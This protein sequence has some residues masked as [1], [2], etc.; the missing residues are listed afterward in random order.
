MSIS[1]LTVVVTVDEKAP[2]PTSCMRLALAL[3]RE[4]VTDFDF[5]LVANA[6]DL[7]TSLALKDF[8]VRVPDSTVVFLNSH[9]P[10]DVARLIGI[11]HA[12]GDYILFCD[13]TEE[14]LAALSALL[15]PLRDGF[16]L[17]IADPQCG[18]ML[19]Q[20]PWL[21]WLLL[22][23]YTRIY[24]L[25]TDVTLESRPTGF[26]VVSRA[27]ALFIARHPA[28]EFMLRIRNIGPG[29][30]AKVLPLLANVAPHNPGS[31]RDNWAAGVKSLIGT[32]TMPLR[33]AAYL[34]L[35]GGVLS[36][37]WGIYAL[38]S[39]ILRSNVAAGWTTISLQIA[40]MMFIFSLLFMLLSEYVL[41]IHASNLPRRLSHLVLRELRS[42][43]SRR[44]MRLNV[45]DAQGRFHIGA[46]PMAGGTMS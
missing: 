41:Q 38:A 29:F 36:L 21:T 14:E 33:A 24:R 32:T 19:I 17:V 23:A 18:T 9:Q 26:R 5:V 42:P 28:A 3:E 30:P 27:A 8:V 12:V 4:D 6:V 34:G 1:S 43:L 11:D 16:D 7:A 40:A 20:R 2:S 13:L 22:R 25:L 45:V 46:P 44:S 31:L 37:L 39:Y 15:A 10:G 35:F